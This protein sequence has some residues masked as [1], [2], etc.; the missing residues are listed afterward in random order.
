MIDN[1][2]CDP[3]HCNP[4]LAEGIEE[5]SKRVEETCDFL[6]STEEHSWR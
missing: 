1:R 6:G 2:H 5:H 4:D 3:E